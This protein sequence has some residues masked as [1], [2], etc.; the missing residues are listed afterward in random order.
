MK[1]CLFYLF[2]AFYVPYLLALTLLYFFLFFPA[3]VAGYCLIG[4]DHLDDAMRRMAQF[5][6][7]Y[8]LRLSWPW[9]RLRTVGFERF[10]SGGPCVVVCNHRCYLDIFFS[11]LIPQTNLL[12]AVRSWP[13]RIPFMGWFMRRAGYLDVE[14]LSMDTLLSHSE[15]MIKRGVSY[16]FFPEGH[17]SRDGRLQRFR[18]GAFRIAAQNNLPVV[19][20][21][22]EGTEK[23]APYGRLLP[24]P[25]EVRIEILDPIRPDTFPEEKRAL[26]L[27]RHVENVFRAHLGEE[28]VSG[29]LENETEP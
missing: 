23:V 4:R 7:R 20:F 29:V 28:L 13:L 22:I 17:R 9:I 12:V 6:G 11:A 27:R 24:R 8:L 15:A 2:H 1:T 5:Y 21:C 18:S 25:A 16:L 3:I 26:L 10:P 14:T 19:P